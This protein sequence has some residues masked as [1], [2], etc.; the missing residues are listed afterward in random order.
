MKWLLVDLSSALSAAHV[1]L[2]GVFGLCMVRL[3]S[4]LGCEHRK[5]ALNCWVFVLLFAPSASSSQKAKER[6]PLVPLVV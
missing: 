4:L 1:L 2:L 3:V 6:S 5:G